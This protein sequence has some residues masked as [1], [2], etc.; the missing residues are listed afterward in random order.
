MDSV[1]ALT[2][3]LD[4]IQ[5]CSCG[6]PKA[7]DL[8]S[9]VLPEFCQLFEETGQTSDYYHVNCV[10]DLLDGNN[11]SVNILILFYY[12]VVSTWILNLFLIAC[13]LVNKTLDVFFRQINLMND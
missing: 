2:R 12:K 10:T 13:T 4:N 7:F 1:F 11:D 8:D 5:T 6:Y 3:V 9:M